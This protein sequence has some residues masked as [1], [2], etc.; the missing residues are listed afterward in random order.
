MLSKYAKSRWEIRI[1]SILKCMIFLLFLLVLLK[2]PIVEAVTF[3]AID[4]LAVEDELRVKGKTGLGTTSPSGVLHVRGILNTALSG[5]VS[6]TLDTAAVTGSSTAFSTE[7]KVGDSI[8]IAGEI[9]TVSE[10][11]NN[12]SL[13][14]DSNHTAGASGVAA[15]KDSDLFLIQNGDAVEKLVL[16]KSGNVGIGETTP[17][18][19]LDIAGGIRATGTTTFN[20]LTYTW[21]SSQ[22]ADYVLSTDGSGNLTWVN[23][24]GISGTVDGSGTINY[25]PKWSDEDTMTD[26]VIYESS[27]NIG[28][29][30]IAPTSKLHVYD[31]DLKVQGGTI[32]L[33]NS[34]GASG[35]ATLD[36]ASGSGYLDIDR[37]LRVNDYIQARDGSG[38][39]LKTDE[40][41]TRLFVKDDGNIGI[42]T[43]APSAKLDV[44]GGIDTTSDIEAV[45]N[46][47]TGARWVKAENLQS[48]AGDHAILWAETEATGGD[49][50]LRLEQDGSTV[51]TVGMDISDSDKLKIGDSSAIGTNTRLTVD[52]I[53]N[54]GIG[55][56]TPTRP[57]TIDAT[58]PQI[59]LRVS[60]SQK[61]QFGAASSGSNIFTGDLAGDFGIK[62]EQK[63]I[64]GVGN[65]MDMVIIDGGN[66]GIGSTAPL[67]KLD[68]VG[69]IYSSGTIYGDLAAGGV[70]GST[71]QDADTD[72][73]IQTEASGDEDYI[74]LS[75]AGT[76]RVTIK[77]D[78]NVG[79]GATTPTSLLHINETPAAE[80]T[81]PTLS[82]GDGDTGFYESVDDNLRVSVGGSQ[83]MQFS[84]N[85]IQGI[86]ST[87]PLVK[88]TITATATSPS[89]APYATDLDTGI[90]WAGS[91]VLSL[92]AGGTNVMNITSGNVGIGTTAP[93]DPLHI[94]SGDNGVMKA[95]STGNRAYITLSDNDTTNYITSEGSLMS[96]GAN[97]G[98][99][100]GN[101]IILSDGNVG[102]GSTAPTKT[103]DVVGDMRVS[104]AFEVA[105]AGDL[106]IAHDLYF[107]N[108]VTSPQITSNKALSIISGAPASNS[109]L[110]LQGRGT[111]KVYIDDNLEVTGTIAGSGTITTTMLDSDLQD[112][113]DGSLTGSK[114]GTGI[115]ATN[116][117]S[118]TLA[119]ARLEATIDRTI[120]NASD[121][122][123]ALGGIHVGG[124]SDPGTDNLVVDG[125][126]GIGSTAPL[127]KLDVNGNIRVAGTGNSDFAG[128]ITVD[129][130]N[131]LI[132]DDNDGEDSYLARSA[133]NV[134]SFF[135]DG[136]EVARCVKK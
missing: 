73:K 53:G 63:I 18:H 2:L 47:G 1:S 54:V 38:M 114:V 22:T 42:G 50:I 111:G 95:Q 59:I 78:G 56:T 79:I 118:G 4:D 31:G 67:Y 119:D 130:G 107:S 12:T 104:N 64:F 136:V 43:T 75:T 11:S 69:D 128:N 106:Y 46:T 27:G 40:G 113:A 84:S 36:Y 117:T 126:V 13:T 74:R 32:N 88:G 55:T 76:E 44:V 135:V 129:T 72:T 100:A 120:F 45:R 24:T 34:T 82:F 25:I 48:G 10:I 3:R 66:V 86:N 6:V 125:S 14:I 108:G 17:V 103:L 81:T 122:I 26:S 92:I 98:I 62:G 116:I 124:T 19:K 41:T 93:V 52:T 99:N 30:T 101:L 58:Q 37:P 15:Y 87:G 65:S 123:T 115:N 85:G 5:T 71:I 28:I 9:F 49:P 61:A 102:I 70:G 121:Y 110:T 133:S 57:L 23:A 89:F 90:G 112:L 7:L 33:R 131:K 96:L 60:G 134:V 35:S 109:D 20:S 29:G 132:L 91:N 39:A 21:P 51:W 83:V 68:V 8:K 80:P 16:D 97:S 105:G 127:E 94:Y 77:S